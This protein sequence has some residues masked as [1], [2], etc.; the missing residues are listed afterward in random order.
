MHVGYCIYEGA[1]VSERRRAR[2]I[3]PAAATVCFNSFR[4][5]RGAPA[6]RRGGP[7]Q[8]TELGPRAWQGRKLGFRFALGEVWR[9]GRA[10][11]GHPPIDSPF[12]DVLRLI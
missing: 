7:V 2:V 5:R 4:R 12:L 3:T 9:A 8:E 10:S 6:G 11:F 1:C